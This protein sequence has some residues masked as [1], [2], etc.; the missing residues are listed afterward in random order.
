VDDTFGNSK[1]RFSGPLL[2]EGCSWIEGKEIIFSS[3]GKDCSILKCFWASW[4]H[5]HVDP[6]FE[7]FCCEKKG[8]CELLSKLLIRDDLGS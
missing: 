3:L 7:S 1:S 8:T 4:L 5:F 6:G 2:V